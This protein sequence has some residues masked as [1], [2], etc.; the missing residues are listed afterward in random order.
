[1]KCEDDLDREIKRANQQIKTLKTKAK[2]CR[3]TLEDKLAI[4][5]EA[6]KAQE[7]SYQLRANYFY[8]QDQVRDAQLAQFECTVEA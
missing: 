6:K 4:N 3:G 2:R 1:I 7:V 5:E 8:I